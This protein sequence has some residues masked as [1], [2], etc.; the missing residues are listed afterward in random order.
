MHCFPCLSRAII[1]NFMLDICQNDYIKC[2][3]NDGE[4]KVLEASRPCTL[5]TRYRKTGT[6]LVAAVTDRCCHLNIADPC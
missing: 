4:Q 3:L 5:P 2:G 1:K 6:E